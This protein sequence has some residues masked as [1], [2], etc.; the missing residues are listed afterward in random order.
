MFK[1][2]RMSQSSVAAVRIQKISGESPI[3]SDDLLT[4]EEPLEIRLGFHDGVSR[5]QQSLS[6]TMRTPGNDFELAL[7]FLFSEGIIRD[8]NDVLSVKY[9]TD[10]N[11][12]EDHENVVRVELHDEIL[13]DLKRLE[14]HFYTSSS[15]GV[16][17]KT[18]LEAVRAVCPPENIST[19]SRSVFSRDIIL[20]LPEKLREAQLVFEYTGGLH[21]AAL[22]DKSGKLILMREDI[23]RHNAVDKLI[24][25]G[26]ASGQIPFSNHI[27]L[28][29]G[30]TGFELVQ[31]SVMAGIK[32]IASVGAPSSLAL[33]LAKEFGITLIGF[34][35]G[36]RFNIY[37]GEERITI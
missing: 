34:L 17:G 31:K 9:C 29:S 37:S 27:L 10:G 1:V 8:Y 23:G 22:F 36:E 4:V 19:E 3:G 28:L 7:G 5:S 20:S 12:N 14:R 25:A 2:G 35:R 11:R 13:P 32:A 24:G 15:C 18:S 6:V 21:A 33:Q 26:L 16:C 30:R